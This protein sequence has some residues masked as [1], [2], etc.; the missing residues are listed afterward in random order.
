[1]RVSAL[2]DT[3]SRSVSEP[4]AVKRDAGKP[5]MD[6]IPPDELLELGAL[7]ALGAVKYDDDNWREGDGLEWNRLYAAA[8][9]HLTKWWAGEDYDDEDGQPHLI[10]VAFCALT[11]R[12][13]S[14]NRPHMDSRRSRVQEP[15]TDDVRRSSEL[16]RDIRR[17]RAELDA[18]VAEPPHVY[19]RTIEF[20]G[21]HGEARAWHQ[22]QR[23]AEAPE[24]P[25][26]AL[27]A[28]VEATLPLRILLGQY[29]L[30]KLG[31]YVGHQEDCPGFRGD[32]CECG[33]AD[34]IRELRA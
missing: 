11:L 13:L 29:G 32:P 3:G 25:S 23:Y 7:F 33:L 24:S 10:A 9:R 26:A 27:D 12:W 21:D 14:K 6:L 15:A 5:R 31:R 2:L 20:E 1:M 28:E 34:T 30:S 17:R 4:V 19:Q 16:F 8:Q 22:P 18:I